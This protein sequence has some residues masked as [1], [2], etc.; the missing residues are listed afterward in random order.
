MKITAFK[1]IISLTLA[2][3]AGMYYYDKLPDP[4]ELEDGSSFKLSGKYVGSYI[5]NDI[6]EFE[7]DGDVTL[8]MEV[9]GIKMEQSGVYKI[10]E[11]VIEIEIDRWKKLFGQPVI[12]KLYSVVNENELCSSR[13]CPEKD[14]DN[15]SWMFTSC[16]H[17]KKVK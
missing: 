6:V 3:A 5:A 15:S 1:V 10:D 16:V 9:F 4:V 12:T 17:L 2:G 11:D 8:T 14:E 7:E 13:K